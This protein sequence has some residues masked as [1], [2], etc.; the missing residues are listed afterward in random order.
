M[1]NDSE[2]RVSTPDLRAIPAIRPAPHEADPALAVWRRALTDPDHG[3]NLTRAIRRWQVTAATRLAA[4]GTIDDSQLPLL[5]A[6][7]D[8]AGLEPLEQS[9]RQV[10]IG[11]EWDH[12]VDL[13][14]SSA[15]SS[16][17]TKVY[18]VGSSLA[19]L[20]WRYPSLEFVMVS[21][22]TVLEFIDAALGQRPL[23]ATW[24]TRAEHHS[25]V[26][27]LRAARQKRSTPGLWIFADEPC[28]F[29]N[30]QVNEDLA[31]LWPLIHSPSQVLGLAAAT[32]GT[33]NPADLLHQQLVKKP[34][35]RVA[36]RVDG[37]DDPAEICTVESGMPA[38]WCLLMERQ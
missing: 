22:R 15:L 30:G 19:T 3:Q 27:A 31:D 4:Q 5:L 14:V 2:A 7:A 1:N 11:H 37:G 28:V 23:N 35:T 12:A 34:L 26:H 13:A 38:V 21:D 10:I 8:R 18:I 20:P 29:P 24:V 32:P 36:V 6:C 16:G 9:P 25:A 33:N 17:L